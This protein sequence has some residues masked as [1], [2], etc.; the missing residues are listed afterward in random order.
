VNLY[1]TLPRPAA[2]SVG[3]W[4]LALAAWKASVTVLGWHSQHE[5]RLSGHNLGFRGQ[6]ISSFS[7]V[8]WN[9]NSAFTDVEAT[10]YTHLRA[11]TR[12]PGPAIPRQPVV[13]LP[14]LKD[15]TKK[16]VSYSP[17][18][19]LPQHIIPCSSWAHCIS[20]EA[21][22]SSSKALGKIPW[23]QARP[24]DLFVSSP[25]RLYLY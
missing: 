24:T 12:N 11:L 21:K 18:P 23:E 8:Y 9:C 5:A 10:I 2:C 15:V 13:S 16:K 6:S 1:L 7:P 3:I 14:K 22:S 17:L 4:K 20:R 19:S 25:L